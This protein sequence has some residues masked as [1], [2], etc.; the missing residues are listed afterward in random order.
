MWHNRSHILAALS[1]LVSPTLKY[2]WE[3]EQQVSCE[4]VK[5]KISKKTLL[6]FTDFNKEFHVYTDAS[7]K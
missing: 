3:D 4:E 5:K 1:G 6:A 7:N 2:N